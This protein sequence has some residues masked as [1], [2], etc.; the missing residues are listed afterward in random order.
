[1][2]TRIIWSENK[3]TKQVFSDVAQNKRCVTDA[4]WDS[5]VA[6]QNE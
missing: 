1:M 5:K 4:N 6:T 3:S 2:S